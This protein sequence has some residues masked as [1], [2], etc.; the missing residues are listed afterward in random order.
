MDLVK[1]YSFE[2]NFFFR[3]TCALFFDV[4]ALPELIR[5]RMRQGLS[6]TDFRKLTLM[7]LG[8]GKWREKGVKKGCFLLFFFILPSIV[9]LSYKP[10][11]DSLCCSS[12]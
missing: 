2:Y 9:V 3:N 6:S 7:A 8:V 11:A 1:G 12:R 5:R 10:P 4:F